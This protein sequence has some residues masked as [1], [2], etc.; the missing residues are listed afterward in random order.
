MTFRQV[1]ILL[2]MD[3]GNDQALPGVS[4]ETLLLCQAIKE[5]IANLYQPKLKQAP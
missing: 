5:T 1:L 4:E 3:E 2:P